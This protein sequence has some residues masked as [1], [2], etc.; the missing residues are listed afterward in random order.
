M[1]SAKAEHSEYAP[2]MRTSSSTLFT[3]LLAPVVLGMLA[4]GP[5]KLTTPV[6]D[7]PKLTTLDAVMDN[8]ATVADPQWS[9]IDATAYT[10]ADYAAFTE[11]S[12]RIQA[13]S[14]KTKDF[15]KGP[16]FDAFAQTLHDKA[17]ELGT[18]AAAKDVK[19]SGTA[20][21]EMKAACK[22]CHSKFK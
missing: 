22:G 12:E 21:R 11:L 6:A 2:R 1:R 14:L 13:T 5:P 17:K 9:K 10:D 19:A 16:E 18:A 15:S 7:I 3:A 8:Q 4:C 20:L